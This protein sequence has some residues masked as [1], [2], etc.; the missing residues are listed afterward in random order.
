MALE[1]FTEAELRALPQM[2]DTTRYPL[3]RVDGVAAFVVSRIEG[4]VG[5]SF[6][7]RTVTDEPHDGGVCDVVLNDPR[8]RSL[9]SVTVAGTPVDL[10][11]LSLRAGVLRY[12]TGAAFA[13]GGHD[14][15]LVTYKTGYAAAVP[16]DVKEAAL[17]WTRWRLLAT[18]SNAEMD[19]RQTQVT[20]EFGG[21]TVFAVASKDRPSGYPDVDA[22]LVDWRDRLNV[23]GFA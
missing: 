2:S 15:V 3:A 23:F 16:G 8:A 18:N 10:A 19:A 12:R 9:V 20:N 13:W 14:N 5:T 22:V 1:Y 7:E 4:F 6:V 17:A 21:T 11:L